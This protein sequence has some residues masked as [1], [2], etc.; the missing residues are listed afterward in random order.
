MNGALMAYEQRRNFC[1]SEGLRRE[2]RGRMRMGELYLQSLR[3][4]GRRCKGGRPHLYHSYKRSQRSLPLRI[5]LCA[6]PTAHL[7]LRFSLCAPPTA[8]L[9]VVPPTARLLLRISYCASPMGPCW[10]SWSPRAQVCAD[11]TSSFSLWPFST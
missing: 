7:P 2:G 1:G 8:H 3:G 4:R 11:G 10:S 5:S 9:P 6:P